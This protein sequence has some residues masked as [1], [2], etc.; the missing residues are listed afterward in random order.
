M[1]KKF[2]IYDKQ[3][4]KYKP[5]EGEMLVMNSSGVFF[6]VSGLNDYYTSIQRL[7]DVIGNYD[8][9]WEEE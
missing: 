7:Y 3:G 6:L 5:K 2:S 4:N 8:V 9:V 1:R